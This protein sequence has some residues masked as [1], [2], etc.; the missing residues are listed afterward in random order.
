MSR[1]I[2]VA[3]HCAC[4]CHL[5]PSYDGAITS[6][7]IRHEQ[8]DKPDAREDQVNSFPERRVFDSTS[9]PTQQ[10]WGCQDDYAPDRQLSGGY[11]PDNVQ[12]GEDG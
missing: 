12:E 2:Y 11:K 8:S 3:A 6:W 4:R 10:S 1:H 7:G 5:P 9:R